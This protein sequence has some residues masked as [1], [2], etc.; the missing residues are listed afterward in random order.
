G[1]PRL[2]PP[3]RAG[4]RRPRAALRVVALSRRRAADRGRRSEAVLAVARSVARVARVAGAVIRRPDAGGR[5][6]L[7]PVRRAFTRRTRAAL[8]YVAL[9]RRRAADRGRGLVPVDA[10]AR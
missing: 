9:A 8:R 10:V 5:A 6:R 3:R 1:P 2:E 7:E 4:P